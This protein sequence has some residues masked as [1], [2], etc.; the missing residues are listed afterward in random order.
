MQWI[1]DQI[2]WLTSTVNGLIRDVT[3]IASNVWT[4][5]TTA[6]RDAYNDAVAWGQG[7]IHDLR[8]VVY[9]NLLLLVAAIQTVYRDI[10]ATVIAIWAGIQRAVSQAID[11]V[12]G[13]VQP[14]VIFLRSLIDSGYAFLRGLVDGAM[15]A[16]TDL[17]RRIEHTL[18][19][20]LTFIDTLIVILSRNG[21]SRFSDLV[22]RLYYTIF[23]F[24]RDPVG[25]ILVA[26][27]GRLVELGCYAMAYALGTTKYT[28]PPVP[29]WGLGTSYPDGEVPENFPTTPGQMTRPV[30]PMYVSGTRFSNIHPALDFGI[31]DGQNIYAVHSGQV[32]YAGWS[33]VGYGYTITIQG[34][35][36]WT[37]YAHLKQCLVNSGDGVIEGQL[38]AYG[39]S[40]GN[41]TGPHLHFEIKINGRF[42]DPAA[43]Y[44]IGG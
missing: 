19:P 26:V 22:N 3:Y 29:A 5:I 24:F 14:I 13:Y 20:Y 39:D 12:T 36:I 38:I 43:V 44:G 34:D 41:S 17:G 7:V 11:Y 30:I 40:T 21:I 16:I 32:E 31:N 8:D 4:R 9:H 33:N 1:Y 18:Q 37:R 23:N 42:V 6:A 28:L 35:N 10:A 25:F 2:Q 15:S 27:W